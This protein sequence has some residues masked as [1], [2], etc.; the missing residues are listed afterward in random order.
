MIKFIEQSKNAIIHSV[1]TT[2]LELPKTFD[3]N[4]F[5]EEKIASEQERTR[6][7]YLTPEIKTMKEILEALYTVAKSRKG[8]DHY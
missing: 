4:Y 5:P 7:P 1:R 8:K 6:K 3:L 2:P